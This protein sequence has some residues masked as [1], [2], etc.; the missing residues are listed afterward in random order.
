MASV[1]E[2]YDDEGTVSY[3]HTGDVISNTMGDVIAEVV[4]RNRR[5]KRAA[6]QSPMRPF[7]VQP[8]YDLWT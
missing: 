8:D 3:L 2:V 6:K 1:Y 4:A 5:E 7:G